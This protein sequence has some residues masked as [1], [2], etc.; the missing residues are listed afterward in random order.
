MKN[1]IFAKRFINGNKYVI[2]A[3]LMSFLSAMI[4]IVVFANRYYRTDISAFDYGKEVYITVKA[5]SLSYS[6]YYSIED[7]FLNMSDSTYMYELIRTQTENTTQDG[8]YTEIVGSEENY[9]IDPIYQ[10][11]RMVPQYIC[12]FS[13]GTIN[14]MKALGFDNLGKIPEK[15]NEFFLTNSCDQFGTSDRFAERKDDENIKDCILYIP[16][17]GMI[18]PVGYITPNIKNAAFPYQSFITG[19]NNLEPLQQM[20]RDLVFDFKNVKTDEE[21]EALLKTVSEHTEV[22][23]SSISEPYEY[24][25]GKIKDKKLKS[26]GILIMECLLV[27][28]GQLFLFNYIMRIMENENYI[29]YLCG[30]KNKFN[31]LQFFMILLL[32]SMSFLAITL[33]VFIFMHMTDL[34]GICSLL[35]IIYLLLSSLVCIAVR[36]FSKI[37]M[38]KK[39]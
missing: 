35:F 16:R 6:D 28:F 37:R 1:V 29:M 10:A 24:Y 11:Y 2:V 14:N 15:S 25:N 31:Y 38:I 20:D 4:A 3:V 26:L 22:K 32:L 18:N 21:I 33:I 7:Y 12:G 9:T 23:D 30:M 5:G 39:M 27:T 17:I 13:E 8:K 36:S 19:I 34:Y